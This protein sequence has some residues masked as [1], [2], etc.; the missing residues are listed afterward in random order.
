MTTD[1]DDGDKL[2]RTTWVQRL[3]TSGGMAP[4]AP[5][6]PGAKLAVPYTADYFFWRARAA[7]QQD[8]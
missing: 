5:C 8:D 2:E 3:N 7:G 1:G 4:A 6:T